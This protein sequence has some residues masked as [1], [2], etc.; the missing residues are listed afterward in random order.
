MVDG[1]IVACVLAGG[2]GT[3]LYPASRSHR[4]KPLLAFGGNRSLLASTLGRTHVADETVILTSDEFLDDIEDHTAGVDVVVE[5]QAKDTGPA[6]MYASWLLR[7]KYDADILVSLPS[8]HCIQ[9]TQRFTDSLEHAISLADETGALVTLGIEPTRPSTEYGYIVPETTDRS[10]P[11]ASFREKPGEDTARE[12]IEAGAK[13]NAGIFVWRPEAFLEEVRQSPLAE[14]LEALNRGEP[15]AAFEAAQSI[16]VDYAVMENADDVYMTTL[17][18]E[19]DDLG[20]WTAVGRVIGE[21][22][23]DGNTVVER[24]DFTSIDSSGNI[25]SAPNKHVSIAG[26]D[27]LVIAEYNDHLLVAPKDE[28]DRIRE[29]VATLRSEGLF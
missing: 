7:E 28:S 16:S 13:W 20:T 2:Y 9:D 25:I 27:D 29:L 17:D 1:P 5:P 24:T 4:P 6:L 21:S 3:R 19:W 10:S 8:D 15:S 23:P 26:V 22:T 14:M 18:V 12:L 11:V